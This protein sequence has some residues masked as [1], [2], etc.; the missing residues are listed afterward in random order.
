[1]ANDIPPFLAYVRSEYLYSLE[2]GFGYF[3][4]ATVFAVSSYPNET[5]KLQLIADDKVMF[6]NVPVCALANSRTAPKIE[7]EDCV[8]DVCPDENITI[9]QYDYLTTVEHCALWKKDGSFWQKGIY[10]FSVEWPKTKSQFHFIELEDG[11]YSFWSNERMT[12]G[13]DIPEKIPEYKK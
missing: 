10:L 3:T 7:E 13:E 11:N 2:E 9:A 5:L 6:P 1:M 4:P 12:W 8:F